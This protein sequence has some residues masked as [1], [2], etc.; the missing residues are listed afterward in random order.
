MQLALIL[1]LRTIWLSSLIIGWPEGN[2][3]SK[4]QSIKF[5]LSLSDG[6]SNSIRFTPFFKSLA[7]AQSSTKNFDFVNALSG[8]KLNVKLNVYKL[9]LL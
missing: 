3:S 1:P 8:I 9:I 2:S 4:T 5:K 7:S 6:P